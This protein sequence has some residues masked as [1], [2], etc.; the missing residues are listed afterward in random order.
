MAHLTM[1][2]DI[3]GWF[4]NGLAVHYARDGIGLCGTWIMRPETTTITPDSPELRARLGKTV[5][6]TCV[7]EM[8]VP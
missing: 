6:V 7:S 8:E 5:C 4:T 2:A 1:R 3:E